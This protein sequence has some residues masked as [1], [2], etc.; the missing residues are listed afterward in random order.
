M[1]D[2]FFYFSW[3]LNPLDNSDNKATLSCSFPF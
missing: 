3:V 1:L 2:S